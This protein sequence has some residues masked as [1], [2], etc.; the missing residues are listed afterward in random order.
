[1]N[2]FESINKGFE[3]KYGDLDGKKEKKVVEC[4]KVAVQKE[5]CNNRV[6]EGV[7]TKL[8]TRAEARK[9]FEN[10]EEIYAGL[11]DGGS[12]FGFKKDDE[13]PTFYDVIRYIT[14]DYKVKDK[15]IQWAIS[16]DSV[17]ESYNDK[18][19]GCTDTRFRGKKEIKVTEGYAVKA[20]DSDK[21]VYKFYD[22][23]H[24]VTDAGEFS[25]PFGD[26]DMSQAYAND[27]GRDPKLALDRVDGATKVISVQ[28]EPDMG[29]ELSYIKGNYP[30]NKKSK[31]ESRDKKVRECA[32]TRFHGNKEI[33]EYKDMGQDLS[34]YQKWVDYD[35]KR[36]HKISDKTMG[37]IKKAG[38][39][40]V[41]DQYGGYEVIAKEPVREAVKNVDPRMSEYMKKLVDVYSNDLDYKEIVEFNFLDSTIDE[42]FD[43]FIDG[44]TKKRHPKLDDFAYDIVEQGYGDK[45]LWNRSIEDKLS[46]FRHTYNYITPR[47]FRFEDFINGD[48]DLLVDVIGNK[49]IRTLVQIVSDKLYYEIIRL[50]RTEYKK[51]VTEFIVYAQKASDGVK[52]GLD[53]I[54]DGSITY[55]DVQ[56]DE[57]TEYLKELLNPKH[58]AS[59]FKYA[60][61][62]LKDRKDLIGSLL[63]YL[64]INPK[65]IRESCNKGKKDVKESLKLIMDIGDYRPWSG[66][67]DTFYK[68]QDADMVGA[69][70]NYL[71]DIYPEGLTVTELNDILWFEGESV[72]RDLG[73]SDEE[74]D[75]DEE[76]D[77]YEEDEEDIDESCKKSVKEGRSID[78]KKLRG[79]DDLSEAKFDI[80]DERVDRYVN[81]LIDEFTNNWD[82]AEVAQLFYYPMGDVLATVKYEYSHK[83]KDD[84]KNHKNINAWVSDVIDVNFREYSGG[85][86]DYPYATPKYF[87]FNNFKNGNARTIKEIIGDANYKKFITAVG[88]KAYKDINGELKSLYKDAITEYIDLLKEKHS[89]EDI[90]SVIKTNKYSPEELGVDSFYSA[91]LIPKYISEF[92]RFIGIG[93]VSSKNALE[94]L[95]AYFGIDLD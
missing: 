42:F 39:S 20:L 40:V 82:W 72:L 34:E 66:A 21:G 47:A 45:G 86:N 35:M 23:V 75:E 44:Q 4:D 85:D 59:F 95:L 19:V 93:G 9:K 2:L 41:K 48:E 77:E 58:I 12:L 73:I 50:L 69:L 14:D 46:L 61:V 94:K 22:G 89:D 31:I 16:S 6:V 30:K 1:M 62:A 13:T 60:D 28:P 26:P 3:S 24:V 83:L 15:D 74:D 91:L 51:A 38:L 84:N 32:D 90:Y 25:V 64:G 7:T 54:K 56:F 29:S 78:F 63:S 18:V 65:T 80:L 55:T 92:F 79:K 53:A 27:I 49:N 68:I 17:K 57:D 11:K 5:S 8:S 37:E 43:L 76:E 70:E 52:S 71:E 33:K 36:Y 87:G 88:N 81:K 10:G 67:V